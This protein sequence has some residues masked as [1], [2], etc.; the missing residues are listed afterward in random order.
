MNI[1]PAVQNRI[2]PQNSAAFSP[3]RSIR[4]S[5]E[6][7]TSPAA[8]KKIT[9]KKIAKLS[10]KTVPKNAVRECASVGSPAST[11]VAII[12]RKTPISDS[13]SISRCDERFC[14]QE[15]VDRQDHA[16]PDGQHDLRQDQERVS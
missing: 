7:S 2:R 16:G 13:T 15:Q 10:T 8:S 9:L 3:T 1:R 14:G 6:S 12:D 11:S 4:L 5:A